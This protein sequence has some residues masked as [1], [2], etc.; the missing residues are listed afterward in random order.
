MSAESTPT[1]PHWSDS[2]PLD[3]REAIRV[4]RAFHE[5]G[6]RT[7]TDEARSA[8]ALLAE[9]YAGP[10]LRAVALLLGS[11]QDAWDVV[12]ELFAQLPSRLA[13][14]RPGNFGAW[15]KKVALTKAREHRRRVRRR[16]EEGVADLPHGDGTRA[17]ELDRLVTREAVYRALCCLSPKLREVVVLR[18]FLDFAHAEIAETL[19]ITTNA[20]QVRLSRAIV[21]MSNSVGGG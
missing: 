9:R 8:V 21:H 10:L 16:R 18:F 3:V 2:T 11:E 12:Q 19:G 17:S 1:N 4:L 6:G 15:L 13:A 14:Y 5:G 20:S 7:L